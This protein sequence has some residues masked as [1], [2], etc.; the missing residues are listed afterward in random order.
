MTAVVQGNTVA[1]PGAGAGFAQNGIRLDTGTN[2]GDNTKFCATIGGLGTL[3]DGTLEKNN[4][5]GTGTNGESDIRIRMRFLTQLGVPGYVGATTG[6][7]TMQTFLMSRNLVSTATATNNVS[8]GG[9][10]YLG[11]C[12]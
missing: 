9:S 3:P 12:P 8:T 2:S 11:A 5:T 4:V 6:D 1:E 7:A 10:G